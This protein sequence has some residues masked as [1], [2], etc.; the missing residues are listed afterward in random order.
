M[1][2][3]CYWTKDMMP[4]VMNKIANFIPTSWVMA[5][6]DKLLYEGKGLAGISMELLILLLFTGVF[7]AGGLFKK[8]DVSK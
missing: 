2:G 7:M 8:V 1:L 6:V 3:G 4:E 5:A